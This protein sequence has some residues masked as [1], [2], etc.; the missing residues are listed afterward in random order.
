[1]KKDEPGEDFGALL[2]EFEGKGGKSRSPAGRG[3]RDR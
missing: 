3:P 1:M 2:E